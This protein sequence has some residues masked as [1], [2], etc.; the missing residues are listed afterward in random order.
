MK[1]A[2]EAEEEAA[3][4]MRRMADERRLTDITRAAA[5]KYK[6]SAEVAQRELEAS[7]A[8]SIQ[9]STQLAEILSSMP[10]EKA[11]RWLIGGVDI[12]VLAPRGVQ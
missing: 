8:R 2:N 10:L 11:K 1:R 4:A 7:R 6:E 3:H 12:N 9:M 5:I